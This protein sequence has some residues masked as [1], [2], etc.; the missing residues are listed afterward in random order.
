M[1]NKTLAAGCSRKINSPGLVWHC[2]KQNR[3]WFLTITCADK[4]HST[5]TICNTL[6]SLFIVTLILVEQHSIISYFSLFEQ[7]NSFL[8]SILRTYDM[9]LLIIYSVYHFGLKKYIKKKEWENILS[10]SSE[11]HDFNYIQ[12]DVISLIMWLV[13]RS[14][15]FDIVTDIVCR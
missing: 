8:F 2:L 13:E 3:S 1:S 5:Y 11:I 12:D 9:I 14:R 7:Q 6:F 15:Y 4:F 10:S